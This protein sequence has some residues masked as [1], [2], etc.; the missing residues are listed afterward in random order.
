MSA[1]QDLEYL[2]IVSPLGLRFSPAASSS[3][4]QLRYW[5]VPMPANGPEPRTGRCSKQYGDNSSRREGNAG[6]ETDNCESRHAATDKSTTLYACR[7]SDVFNVRTNERSSR[8]TDSRRRRSW[9]L[10]LSLVSK[11]PDGRRI[12]PSIRPVASISGHHSDIHLTNLSANEIIPS[13]PVTHGEHH[14]PIRNPNL[15]SSRLPLSSV[16]E[17][18]PALVFTSNIIPTSDST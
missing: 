1:R 8:G 3:P 10:C 9:Q 6:D 13:R 18:R 7:C 11:D 12:S 5:F 15:P 17:S 14:R 16:L 2:P 4:R